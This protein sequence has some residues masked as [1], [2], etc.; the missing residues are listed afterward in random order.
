MVLIIAHLIY[1]LRDPVHLLPRTIM[2]IR[3]DA[4][5]RIVHQVGIQVERLR[6]VEL[7]VRHRLFLRAPV[8]DMNR[9][10]VACVVPCPEVIVT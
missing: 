2:P 8:R 1:L 7:R 5:K 6:I 3:I 4:A 9:P 10:I